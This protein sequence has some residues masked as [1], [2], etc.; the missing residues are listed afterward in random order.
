MKCKK[1]GQFRSAF[2]VNEV[3]SNLSAG[4]EKP[5]SQTA[6]LCRRC[7]GGFS[8]PPA[9]LLTTQCSAQ[10]KSRKIVRLYNKNRKN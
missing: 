4:F 2:F 10:K 1:A 3:V 8:K 9:G 7:V 5:A 6:L